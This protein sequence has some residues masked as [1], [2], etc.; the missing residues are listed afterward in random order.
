MVPRLL[1]GTLHATIYEIDKIRTGCADCCG[2]VSFSAR[3]MY[4][5]EKRILT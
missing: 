3:T 1:H 2:P 4:T 5:Y